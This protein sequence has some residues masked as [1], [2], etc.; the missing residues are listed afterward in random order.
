MSMLSTSNGGEGPRMPARTSALLGSQL[1]DLDDLRCVVEGPRCGKAARLDFL[2]CEWL[3]TNMSTQASS[4]DRQHSSFV[5][6]RELVLML[7]NS[8]SL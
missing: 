6:F 2:R 1:L 8:S 7:F 5:I 4:F 3:A